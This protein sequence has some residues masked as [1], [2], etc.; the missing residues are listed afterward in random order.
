MLQGSASNY[1]VITDTSCFIL[2]DKINAL[3]VL[4]LVYENIL[5]TPEIAAEFKKPLPKW[6]SIIPVK[7]TNLVAEYAQK[8]DLGEASAIALALET[9]NSLLIVDDFKGR[10]LATQL[11]IKFTGTIGILINARQ[12]TIISSLKPYFDLIK[13]TDFRIDPI[14]LDNILSQFED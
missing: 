4:H 8:V 10:R 13:L 12:Q 9:P 2:L 1:A 5:T 14:L 6:I 11:Q 7:A 3:D